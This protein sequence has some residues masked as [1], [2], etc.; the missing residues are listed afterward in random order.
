MSETKHNEFLEN[1]HLNA[2]IIMI[3]ISFHNVFINVYKFKYCHMQPL[4]ILHVVVFLMGVFV[5]VQ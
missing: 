4:Q 5:L 1:V 2:D 3:F